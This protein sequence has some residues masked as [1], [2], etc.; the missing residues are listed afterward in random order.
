MAEMPR[1]RTATRA[2]AAASEELWE[3]NAGWWRETFCDGHDP[4]YEDQLI[5]LVVERVTRAGATQVLELGAG[6]GQICRALVRA[7]VPRVV[8]VEPSSAQRRLFR[9]VPGLSLIGGRAEEPG[10]AP[11]S[12]DFVVISLVLEH[13]EEI[14][15]V[16]REVA[17][18]LRPAGRL[19]VLLNHPLFQTPGSGYVEDHVFDDAYWRVGPYL[20]AKG[21]VEEVD[22]G[23][24]LV[25]FHR[26]LSEYVNCFAAAG[27]LLGAMSEPEPPPRY[28]E[29]RPV[30]LAACR[31]PRL[32]VMEMIRTSELVR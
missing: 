6:E 25:F 16:A 28:F 21:A 4:E 19:L 17:R 13:I 1:G 14:E 31:V 10:L 20:D 11:A 8:A 30:A 9:R 24:Q 7:G 32:M 12:F 3:Q 18:V 15:P 27:L 2:L 26:P 23:V 29:D 5:P 22:R